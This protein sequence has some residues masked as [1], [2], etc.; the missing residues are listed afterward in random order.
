V[1]DGFEFGQQYD[2][3]LPFSHRDC[4]FR[5]DDEY[6]ILV[7]VTVRA[8]PRLTS[9]NLKAP[10]FVNIRNRQGVQVI[11]DDPRYST[12]FP[13]WSEDQAGGGESGEQGD[14]GR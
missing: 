6:A 10:L 1:V 3:R 12:R 8:D 11:Y 4:D 2:L 7:I 13:L 14:E 9:A 5:D